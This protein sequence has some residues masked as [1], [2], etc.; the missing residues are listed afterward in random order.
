MHA[1]SGLWAVCPYKV[2]TGLCGTVQG[3]GECISS[4]FS[5]WQKR[6]ASDSGHIFDGCERDRIKKRLNDSCI[7][8]DMSLM[9]WTM[10]CTPLAQRRRVSPFTHWAVGVDEKIESRG[11]S[12]SCLLQFWINSQMLQINYIFF[13]FSFSPLLSFLQLSSSTSNSLL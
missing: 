13:C 12:N 7:K 11:K 4:C 9:T 2:Q 1:N 3:C 10:S 5:Y 8:L 6:S